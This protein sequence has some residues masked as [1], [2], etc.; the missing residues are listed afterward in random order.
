MKYIGETGRS[1]YER[2]LEHLKDFENCD[3]NSHILKHYLMYH[4]D[5]KRSDMR[6]GMRLRQCFRTPIERQIGEA[7]AIDR[8]SRFGTVLMNSKS[9]YNRCTIERISTKSKKQTIEESEREAEEAK[10]FKEEIQL[11]RKKKREKKINRINDGMKRPM[12][13]VRLGEN[14]NNEKNEK[15]N[16]KCETKEKNEK[17]NEKCETEENI[18]ISP[19][20]PPKVSNFEKK[21]SELNK[22]VSCYGKIPKIPQ[23]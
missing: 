13:K 10:K 22:K 18:I 23:I 11:I 16:E 12:K 19:I 15:E 4:R 5:M 20:A 1:G 17:E 8:E 3:E 14:E 9:E 21:M 2:G 6:F 7:V